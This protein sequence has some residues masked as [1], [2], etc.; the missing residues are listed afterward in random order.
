L[1]LFLLLLGTCLTARALVAADPNRSVDLGPNIL[2]PLIMSS[3][4]PTTTNLMRSNLGDC[5]VSLA[6]SNICV[7]FQSSALAAS[8]FPADRPIG[9]GFYSTNSRSYEVFRLAPEYAYR[10]SAKSENGEAIA[11]TRLGARW[12]RKFVQVAAYDKRTLD[13]SSAD[14]VEYSERGKTSLGRSRI[15]AG[16]RPFWTVAHQALPNIEKVFPP[17]EYLFKF[18]KPGRYTL[19]VETQCFS[20]PLSAGA[21]NLYLVRFPPVK[22]S[23]FKVN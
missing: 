22:L 13:W 1:R 5:V 8:R 10:I 9:V 17:P 7:A 11:A 16:G 19:Y 2:T 14:Y 4:P 3:N 21:T 15:Y 6:V 12:G 18:E 23:V 20:R